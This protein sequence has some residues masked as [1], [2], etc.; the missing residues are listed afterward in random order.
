[1]G[2]PA[3]T[4]VPTLSRQNRARQGRG[5]RREVNSEGT[6]AGSRNVYQPIADGV[7]DQFSGLVNPERVHDI[8][9]IHDYHVGTEIK[10]VGNFFVGFPVTDE[11]QN[12]DFSWRQA[13]VALALEGLLFG[14]L[15]IENSLAFYDAPDGRAEFKVHC[16]L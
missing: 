11:L 16:V 3:P 9:A 15:G 12:L 10:L 14:E 7:Y 8:D 13:R 2:E 1:M 4:K 6:I 5:T